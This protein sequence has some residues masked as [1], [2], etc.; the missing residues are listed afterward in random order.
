MEKKNR[1]AKGR[2][3]SMRTRHPT[4]SQRHSK[5]ISL[6]AVSLG[7]LALATPVLAQGVPYGASKED[8]IAALADMQPVE[9]IMQSVSSP[10]N[11]NSLPTERY[12]AAV[13]DWSGGKITVK[14]IYGSAIMQ[15]NTAPAV[16]DGRITY[17]GV[18]AQY[19]PSNLPT[20]AALVDL[21]FASNALPFSGVLQS[22]GMML[23]TSNANEQAWEEQRNYGIEPGFI[24]SGAAPSGLFCREAR[25]TS[26]ELEGVQTRTGG[27]MHARQVEGLGSANVSLPYSEMFEGLQRGI[28]DCALTSLSTAVVAGIIP[29]APFH[30][31]VRNHN[32]A[33]TATNVAFDQVFWEEVPLEARQLLYDLQKIYI[34]ASI[35]AA[36]IGAKEGLEIVADSG[37]QVLVM[38]QETSDRLA[39]V[40]E[41]LLTELRQSPYFDNGN[42]VVDTL[43][44]AADKWDAIVGELGYTAMDPGWEDF[45]T[46]YD[47]ASVD[48]TA[49]IDRLYQE[50][51]L[52]YR[53][54]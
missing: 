16:A 21:T 1:H 26:A 36:Y 41:E 29:V 18:I 43:L 47:D 28:I 11:P 42:E 39:S 44:V 4:S 37:G 25:S 27:V 22:W 32:F 14:I 12:A 50:T 31:T 8:F 51:M 54:E 40:N 3:A 52:P 6:A 33:L 24:A 7:T 23:E 34:D 53:P 49:F 35:R 17:G 48:L 19:D 30:T 5:F 38:D 45:G 15:G 46:W 2:D 20:S 10:G 9:M 13:E